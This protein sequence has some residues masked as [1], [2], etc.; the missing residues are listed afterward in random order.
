M[1]VRIRCEDKY[2]SQK[3][4][5]LIYSSDSKETDIASVLDT[6]QNELVISLR[7]GSAHS[8]LLEDGSQ[9]EA[10]ADFVQSVIER[11]H[12]IVRA[13]ILGTSVEIAK[14]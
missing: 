2:E 7:D 13:T 10:F 8:I 12:K 3:L 5:G 11:N 9:A 6:I 1:I 4:A 14:A